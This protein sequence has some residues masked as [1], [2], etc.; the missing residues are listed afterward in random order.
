MDFAVQSKRSQLRIIEKLDLS[1]LSKA[2][3]NL[4]IERMNQHF[5]AL[6]SSY[7]KVYGWQYDFFYHLETLVKV[8][9]DGFS[10]RSS[11]L[12][13]YDAQKQKNPLWYKDE[14]MLGIACYVDLFGGDLKSLQ[15]R[16]PYF[17]DMGI[18]YVHLMP[19]YK[20]PNGDS[21][22]GYA[23]SDY[24]SVNPD[25]GTMDDLRNLAKAFHK[26]GINMVLDFVFNHTSDD[27]NWAEQAKKGSADHQA[28]YLM[29]DDKTIP[30]QYEQDLREIFP[31]V[32][33]GNFS[34]NKS[35]NKWVWTTFNNFQWDL[36]YANSEVF[37]AIA[38]EMLF[39]AN[40]GCDALRL[41]ALAFIWKEMGTNC[42]N[43][44]KAHT[45][46]QAFNSCLKIVAPAVV[47]KSEAI[48]H[49]NEVI[50][51]IDEDECQLSYN[52]LLM[53]LIWNS[54]ATRETDLLT[55]SM[56]KTG[57]ISQQCTWVNYARCHDDIGWTF[58]DQ[59]ADELGING[60]DHRQFLNQFYTGRFTGSF[61]NGVAFGENPS[62]G[63]CRV[64]GSL[65]SLCGLE[66]AKKDNDPFAI[67][68]ATKRILLI[69][70]IIMSIGGLP[71]LYAGDDFGL[72][73]D[74][75]F[76]K[77]PNKKHDAR[78]VNRISVDDE[79]LIKSPNQQLTKALKE[80]IAIR[81]NQN[82]FG[83]AKT[84]F[85]DAPNSH[86]FAY[87]RENKKNLCL[88]IANFSEHEV[89][90]YPKNFEVLKQ[91]SA[92]NL[93]NNK[94][95]ALNVEQSLKAYEYKWLKVRKIN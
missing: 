38:G 25:L 48:V 55:A 33:R 8:L 62:N 90:L 14:N 42:E 54:L 61:A 1:G 91:S 46:I 93:C 29:F 94:K 64:C 18:N 66:Q 16:I 49:P 31:Q 28:F 32:R 35:C 71:L 74:Y 30:N 34:Y 86:C 77:D 88:C 19:L 41:D 2:Q 69:H 63:D 22:G 7:Y 51:Y 75:S 65:A 53:A 21:D 81:Q 52:P 67:S 47:F 89:I 15:A 9:L 57:N 40:V 92:T 20:T 17:K 50:K 73:N 59:I 11:T 82:I 78:W 72:L 95:I 12:K 83:D 3:Q 45:L 85:L 13:K 6:F 79:M 68:L 24:R 56:Q 27:H 87:L 84:L 39:L 37:N 4:F 5:P 36:N 44:P 10:E 80:M 58:D 70:S 26:A 60:E 23:V 76:E 43:Q